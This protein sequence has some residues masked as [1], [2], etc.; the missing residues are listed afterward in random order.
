MNNYFLGFGEIFFKQLT[1]TTL[2]FLP[3]IF[4]TRAWF[5]NISDIRTFCPLHIAVEPF[6]ITL[7]TISNS[8]KG[9]LNIFWFVKETKYSPNIEEVKDE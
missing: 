3:P 9:Y 1:G 5:N 2:N 7:K 8:R 4:L 6:F